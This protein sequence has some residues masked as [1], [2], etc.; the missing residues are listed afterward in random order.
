MSG[1][2]P[3]SRTTSPAAVT[4]V[5]PQTWCRVKPYLRQWAPPL[6]SATLPPMLQTEPLLGS[7]A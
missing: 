4:I 3:P 2:A 7:G 1:T 5:T 6:F